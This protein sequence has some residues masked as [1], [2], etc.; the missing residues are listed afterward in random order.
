VSRSAYLL[1]LQLAL[2]EMHKP[3]FTKQPAYINHP[4]VN[5]GTVRVVGVIPEC[6][7]DPWIGV[8]EVGHLFVQ[9]VF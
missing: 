3:L 7:R 9:A 6:A 4:E 5:F 1:S 8:E 2:I